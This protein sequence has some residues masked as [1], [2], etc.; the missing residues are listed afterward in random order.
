MTPDTPKIHVDCETGKIHVDCDT[1]PD[2]SSSVPM[3][4][5]PLAGAMMGLCL[6]GPV[7]ISKNQIYCIY[8]AQAQVK[9]LK[10]ELD[11]T[12]LRPS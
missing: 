5:L 11:P 1:G 7:S 6:G 4:G 2:Y 9:I 12:R 3:A 10:F 8:I